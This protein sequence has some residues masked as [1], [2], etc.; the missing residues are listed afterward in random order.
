VLAATK[1]VAIA[2]LLRTFYLSDLSDRG[3]QDGRMVAVKGEWFMH[4][5]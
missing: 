2:L 4:I 5:T 1:K 3:V